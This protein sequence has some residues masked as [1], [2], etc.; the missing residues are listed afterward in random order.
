MV[1]GTDDILV[2]GR[3]RDILARVIDDQGG[4]DHLSESRLQL[5]RRFAASAAIAEQ[6]EARLARGEE[7][8]VTQHAVLCNTL[9]RIAQIIGVDRTARERAPKLRDYLR[10]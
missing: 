3:Y 8:N 2:S 10:S 7:I 5:S 1:P 6:M 4:T 9:V